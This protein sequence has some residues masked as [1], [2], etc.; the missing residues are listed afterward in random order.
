M[1]WG[2]AQERIAQQIGA[3]LEVF[4]VQF[5]SQCLTSLAVGGSAV[6]HDLHYPR[7]YLPGTSCTGGF[8]FYK[9]KGSK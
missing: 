5:S 9:G 7:Y 8:Q 3:V 4:S 6:V 2:R 1:G